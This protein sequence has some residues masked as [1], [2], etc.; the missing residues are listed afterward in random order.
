[1]EAKHIVAVKR[2]YRRPSE[3]SALGQIIKTNQRLDKLAT[4][5]V[6]FTLRGMM[7]GPCSRALLSLVG[8]RLVHSL[9]WCGR[10]IGP[11]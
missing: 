8:A 2:P 9:C 7:R 11:R 1:M 10:T 5:H 6:D 3:H 4:I